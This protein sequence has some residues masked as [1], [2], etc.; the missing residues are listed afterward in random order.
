MALI[1]TIKCIKCGKTNYIYNNGEVCYECGYIETK[2][3][4][5]NYFRLL[6]ELSMEDRVRKIEEWIYDYKPPRTEP[7][8]F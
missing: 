5:D 7:M 6:D 2:K 1:R 3:Q 4:K 8:V